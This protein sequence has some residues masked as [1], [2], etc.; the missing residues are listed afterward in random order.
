MSCWNVER[1]RAMISILWLSNLPISYLKKGMKFWKII[2]DYWQAESSVS[3]TQ[4]TSVGQRGL[5]STLWGPDDLGMLQEEL[6][7]PS[8]ALLLLN[9]WW[10]HIMSFINLGSFFSRERVLLYF[11]GDKFV[12]TVHTYMVFPVVMYQCESWT[13]KK[14][15]NI[16]ND[17]FELWCSRRLLS[18][19]WTEKRST[20]TS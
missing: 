16:R 1:C 19:A 18:V 12:H 7:P 13:I 6:V 14:A 11:L 20:S 5:K 10:N 8:M 17:S 4:G 2:V 9:A 3:D 15:E